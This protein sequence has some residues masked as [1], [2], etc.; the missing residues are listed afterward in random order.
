MTDKREDEFWF[1]TRTGEVEK[2]KQ[3][4]ASER[5][6]PFPT[7]EAA[8]HANEKLAENARKWA[9]EEAQAEADGD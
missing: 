1:N 6:G 8:A 4:I 3:S 9:E 7:A 5:L 2:G